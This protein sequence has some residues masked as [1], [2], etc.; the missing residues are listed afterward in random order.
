MSN[1]E[2][3][4]YINMLGHFSIQKGDYILSPSTNRTKQVF[5]LIGYLIANRKKDISM[6]TLIDALGEVEDMSINPIQSLKNL[7]YRAKVLLRQELHDEVNNYIIS[8]KGV[9]SW[10]PQLPCIIDT[11]ELELLSNEAAS[12][13]TSKEDRIILYRQA[14]QLYTG[15]FLS[16]SIYTNWIISTTVHY[17]SLYSHCVK[18]CSTLLIEEERY[19]EAI[20]LCKKALNFLIYEE[21]I[22]RSLIYALICTKQITA[23]LDHYRYVTNLFYRDMSAKLSD[24]FLQL[25]NQIVDYIKPEEQD[26]LDIE[27]D[28]T[29]LNS[30]KGAYFCDYDV[31]KN[32][33]RVH[34]RI[35]Q[36]TNN[37]TYVILFSLLTQDDHIPIG[38]QAILASGHLKSALLNS[39]RQ[40][41]TVASYS[42][43]QFIVMLPL[44]TE[45]NTQKV[46]NRITVNFLKTYKKELFKLTTNYFEADIIR[47]SF[48]K[49][50]K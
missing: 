9:Y 50:L 48:K 11:E 42:P 43:T 46:I 4:I 21:S 39:L 24:S 36:R 17:H 35:L 44:I 6:N 47:L 30:Q 49:Q 13:F 1:V 22:H 16:N 23:A 26:I 31:F 12:P 40:G 15:P 38:E 34:T 18:S 25:Y 5:L 41:D 10:N 19:D 45:E 27:N 3:P 37:T 7:V 33:Y 20:E 32:L 28:M 8:I 2:D 29:E 14:C